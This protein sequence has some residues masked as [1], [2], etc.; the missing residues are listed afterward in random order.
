MASGSTPKGKLSE[1]VRRA[2]WRRHQRDEGT[3]AADD[4]ENFEI[5]Q[6]IEAEMLAAT[7]Q[8]DDD[9]D[10]DDD[11]DTK[12]KGAVEA[13]AAWFETFACDPF[14]ECASVKDGLLTLQAN[15]GDHARTVAPFDGSY[16]A[17]A[18]YHRAVLAGLR[19]KALHRLCTA[20]RALPGVT[21]VRLVVWCECIY[22]FTELLGGDDGS[23]LEDAESGDPTADDPL[24]GPHRA[25][26][27][28]VA[29]D[30]TDTKRLFDPASVKTEV[31]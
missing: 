26:T 6:D 3:P 18:D 23:V 30:L 21:T 9:D 27:L 29:L 17:A 1:S 13:L 25:G 11:D 19:Q 20:A 22:R 10:D 8:H 14:G 2:L 31:E 24:A 16:S 12:T 7:K 4:V 5:A 15:F 28:L